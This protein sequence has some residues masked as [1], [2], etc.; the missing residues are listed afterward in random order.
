MNHRTRTSRVTAIAGL[1]VLVLGAATATAQDDADRPRR[2]RDVKIVTRDVFSKDEARENLFFGLA[3]LLHSTTKD[4]VV[5]REMWF[6]RGD[7]VTDDR[8]AELERNLRALNLFGA[9]HATAE[10]VG[11]DEVDVTVD[12]RDRFSLGVTASLSRVGGVDKLYFQLSESNL[13]GTGK[14]IAVAHTESDDDS[15]SSVQYRDPQFL[16]SWHTLNA[17]YGD[18]SEGYFADFALRRP[19][20]NLEDPIS[21]GIETNLS[22]EDVDY[23]ARG[24]SVAEVPL[25]Q[26][27]LRLYGATADGPR[28]ERSA[29]GV[30]LRLR[31]LDY[32]PAFG[33]DAGLIHVPGDTTQVEIGPY[34]TWDWRPRFDTVTG[35]D[36]LDYQED[37][38]IGSSTYLRVAARY[39]DEDGA[40]AELQPVLEARFRV[41][42]NPA[43]ATYVTFEADGN[44]RWNA[45]SVQGWRTG[46][47]LH[48]YQMSL[49]GNTFAG[50]LTF[51]AAEEDQ[52][53]PPQLTLGENNGLRGYPA[54]ELVGSRVARLNLEDRVDTGLELL[55]I[56]IGAV[57]FYD[58][59]WVHDDVYGASMS[60]P[61]SSVG[62]GLRLGSSHLF[63]GRVL[64]IDVAWPLS[65]IDGEEF[66]MTVS[67]AV[68]QVF[69]FFGNS[70][71]LQTKF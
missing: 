17:G 58:V 32:E 50:S 56:R 10:A 31:A 7:E 39:R 48:G 55:S 24:D 1:A 42:A 14:G 71:E 19:F 6:G 43:T 4:E 22:D 21:Y 23:Y 64:R 37:L 8:L 44:A 2:L 46:L 45:E 28:E 67:F 27:D 70:N 54:R 65:T 47:A 30:D 5:R 66:D 29:L 12:A 13:F 15:V 51:D 63:G 38:A 11:E 69:T 18:T 35:L 20:R 62:F 40:D 68:G 52:D 59:G 16:G 25:E 49:P 34:A 9:V 41:A 57:A 33:P 61:I 36:S 3:N 26:H 60:D 53:L